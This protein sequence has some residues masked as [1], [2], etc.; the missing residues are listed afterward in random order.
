MTWQQGDLRVCPPS[1]SQLQA[2]GELVELGGDDN[3]KLQPLHTA[4]LL[5]PSDSSPPVLG[6][7]RSGKGVRILDDS[8]V[9]G[10]RE[11]HVPV[12]DSRSTLGRLMQVCF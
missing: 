1:R 3:I 5:C 4:V 11:Y 7:L 8:L 9:Q 10:P 2:L 6:E 12:L